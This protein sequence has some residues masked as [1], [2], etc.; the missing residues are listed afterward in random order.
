MI[1]DKFMDDNDIVKQMRVLY[2]R[3]NSINKHFKAC[4]DDVNTAIQVKLYKPILWLPV[5]CL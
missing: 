1:G 4:T 5:V 2:T 3:G